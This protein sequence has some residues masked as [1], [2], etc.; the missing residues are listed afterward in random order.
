MSRLRKIGDFF[1]ERTGYRALT[2]HLLEEPIRGGARWA[3]VFGSCLLAVFTVQVVT[4]IALM[5]SY[6]PSDK[7]AWASVHYIQFQQAGGWLLRGL[8]HHGAQAMVILLGAHMAQVAFFGAYKRPREVTW[9]IGLGLFAITLGFALTGYL[10]P[11]DQKGYWATRVATN[12]A[13]TVPLIGDAT[14]KLLQG[15]PEYGSLTLTRFYALHVVV[16]PASLALLAAL[17]VALFRKHG[18]T[19]AAKADVR[20][21]DPFFP[22]QLFRDVIA[23][24]FVVGVCLAASID[25]HGAP[26]DAP[27]DPSSDYPARPEWYFLALFQLL[28]Y[29]HGPMEIV[30]TVVLPTLAGIYLFAL[31]LIDKKEST[32]LKGRIGPLVPLFAMGIGVVALTAVA[33]RDDAKDAGFQKERVKADERA[34]AANKLAMNGVPPEGPLAMLKS[35]PELRGPELF[36]KH[37]AGCHTLGDHGSEKDRTAPK[38]DAWGTEAWIMAMLHDPDHDSRFGRTAYKGEMPSMDVKPKDAD[39]SWKPMSQ[40]DMKNVASFLARE[41]DPEEKVSGDVAKGKEIVASRCTACHLY[42][43]EGDI[44]DQGLAPELSGYGSVAW[45]RAQIANPSSKATYRE[46]ALDPDRKGHM[47]RFDTE[48]KPEDIDLLAAWVRSEARH[49]GGRSPCLP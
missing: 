8:H 30:G 7:T 38:L 14:Q 36:D 22:K 42:E 37:C 4:G 24:C 47:P 20:I 10:L 44:G 26:L 29:F 6:A 39:E 23:A 3:Y 9:W 21:A 25:E 28:K 46:K 16:L 33:M 19:P 32:A 45:V 13:G 5:T 35:A 11:W 2:K 31:P 27:A 41:G 40:E 48:L 12:I 18:V 1:D 15:G 34:Q 49:C 43:G 17:H